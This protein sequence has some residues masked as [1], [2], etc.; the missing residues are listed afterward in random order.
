[1]LIKL[2]GAPSKP[3][4]TACVLHELKTLGKDFRG[5]W[6]YVDCSPTGGIPLSESHCLHSVRVMYVLCWP[7]LL[8]LFLTLNLLMLKP[9]SGIMRITIFP[10]I[11][12]TYS[13]TGVVCGGVMSMRLWLQEPSS[14]LVKLV[15]PT[16]VAMAKSTLLPAA[17]F[18]PALV[19]LLPYVACIVET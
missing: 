8:T 7:G 18:L 6:K 2:L 4:V 1:M 19:L 15:Q 12:A 16:T 10:G 3:L 9:H 11:S 5:K 14:L 17:A 13:S